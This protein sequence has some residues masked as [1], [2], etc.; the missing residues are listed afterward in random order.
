MIIEFGKRFSH[1]CSSLQAPLRA[2]GGGMPA[3]YR[4]SFLFLMLMTVLP[5]IVSCTAQ[6]PEPIAKLT[7][8]YA[9]ENL[10]AWCIVP[11]DTENRDPAERVALLKE[12]G[13][14]RMAWD[15]RMEHLPQLAEEIS[16][17]RDNDIELTAVWFWLDNRSSTGLL[18]H[19]EHILKTIAEEG[20]ETTLWVSF[21][22]DFFE[23]IQDEE[24]VRKGAEVIALI[25]NRAAESGT[26]VALYNHGDWFGEPENQIRIIEAIGSDDIGLVYNFHHGHHQIENFPAMV[27][28]MLPWLWTVNLNGMRQQGPKI[29][30]IGKG[31]HEAGMMRILT[32]SGFNGTIGIIGHT[33]D[34]DVRKPLMRNLDGLKQILAETGDTEAVATYR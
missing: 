30:D 15:W 5:A 23:G 26:R 4:Y 16:V 6:T 21:D 11:F 10:V 31:D 12:L 20:A 1:G 2:S 24:K 3:G 18:E 34:E 22:N 7:M 9:K 25:R 14:T 13:F 29:M 33:E 27:E 19:H 32:E 28:M 17:L 8:L